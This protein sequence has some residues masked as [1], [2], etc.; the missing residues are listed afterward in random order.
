MT[1]ADL[2]V[3]VVDGSAKDPMAQIDAVRTVI[4]EIGGGDM[5]EL[6]VL[7]KIDLL[8]DDESLRF[9]LEGAVEVS[10][11]TGAGLEDLL[12]S[13]AARLHESNRVVALMVPFDRGDVLAAIH[14]EGDVLEQAEG[15]TGM[16]I[17]VLLD[18]VG[19][20]RFSNYEVAS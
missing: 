16:L 10:T 2:I 9:H 13:I 12:N 20:A 8:G 15:P 19:K 11:K 4:D 3:H 7:N 5:P 6:L 14:R 1:Q 17:H 18:E